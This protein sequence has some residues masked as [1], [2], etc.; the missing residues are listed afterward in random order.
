MRVCAK[1][2]AEMPVETGRGR[3]RKY[4]EACNPSRPRRKPPL[5]PS[6]AAAVGAPAGSVLEATRSALI[7]AGAL[8]TPMGQ[9]ALVLA[10]CIDDSSE[11]LAARTQAVKQLGAALSSVVS[12]EQAAPADP[13]DEFTRKRLA[14]EHGA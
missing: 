7:A 11:P 6:V 4:C 3:R 9:A 10:S 14:R 13:N 1:C 12:A 8:S 2:S 5:A